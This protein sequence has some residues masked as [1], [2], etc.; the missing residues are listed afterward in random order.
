M[1]KTSAN[2]EHWARVAGEWIGWARSPNHDAFWAYRKSLIAFIGA[3]DGEALDVGC[4]EGRV[5]RELKALGYQVTASDAVVEMIEAA[6]DANSAHHYAVADAAALPF[7]NNGFDLVVAYNVLM[8]VERVPGASVSGSRGLRQRGA[9]CPL[10]S[11]RHLLRPAT[12]RRERGTQWPADAFKPTWRLWR[13][14]A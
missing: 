12:L 11:S 9:G 10:R 8:D 13:G 14:R 7:H 1:R 3:G 6:V 2:R 4:G 5:S